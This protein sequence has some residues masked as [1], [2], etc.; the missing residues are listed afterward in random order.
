[1]A[2]FILFLVFLLLV[3]FTIVF[4][5]ENLTLI[6]VNLLVKNIQVPLGITMLFCF[7]FGS[8][9]GILFSIGLA[10]K[11]KSKARALSKKVQVAEQEIANLRQLPI[12]SS[13]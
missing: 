9:I 12:K 7:I 3:F 2:R 10:I 5:L 11:N 6:P 8:L 1:M 13:Q 4:T